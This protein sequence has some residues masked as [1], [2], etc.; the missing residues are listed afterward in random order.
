MRFY[1]Q[2]TQTTYLRGMHVSMPVDAV[3]IPDALYQDVIGNP[4]AGKV[5]AHDERGLPYLIDAPDM[6][7][8]LATQEREWRDTELASV[9]WLRERHRD[10]AEIGTATTLAGDQ[11]NELLVYIQVLRDWPQSPSFPDSKSRPE[12]PEWAG[13]LVE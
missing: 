5:R 11:F 12:R 1:S 13:R 6:V 8:D 10:Q 2:T 9:M 7:L 3:E 4:P